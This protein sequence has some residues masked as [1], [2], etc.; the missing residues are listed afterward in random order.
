M[1][2]K[3]TVFL[4]LLILPTISFGQIKSFN[5]NKVDYLYLSYT[6]G[7]GP[8]YS[9]DYM[10]RYDF[11]YQSNDLIEFGGIVNIWKGLNANIGFGFATNFQD[12]D[13]FDYPQSNNADYSYNQLRGIMPNLGLSYN[14]GYSFLFF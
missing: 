9:V 11:L 12:I 14:V 8:G 13:L 7:N 5:L 1:K 3:L 10:D 4:A 6:P 2:N